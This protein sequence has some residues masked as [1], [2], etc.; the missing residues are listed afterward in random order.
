MEGEFVGFFLIGALIF[1]CIGALLGSRVN[2]GFSSFWWGFF[3]GP[4][5]WVIILL[6]PRG[7]QPKHTRNSQAKPEN[8]SLDNDLY[9]VWLVDTYGIQKNDVL[10]QYL[11]SGTLFD[12][13][14]LALEFAHSNEGLRKKNEADAKTYTVIWNAFKVI[15]AINLLVF[16]IKVF[17]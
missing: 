14:D 8:A 10:D 7:N 9:R 3:L 4:I 11:C 6:L 13:I 5:G 15:V 1:G 17:V 2:I 16:V 12:T